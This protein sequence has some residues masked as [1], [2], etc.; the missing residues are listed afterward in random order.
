MA[1]T[2]PIMASVTKPATKEKTPKDADATPRVNIQDFCE[3]HYEDIMPVIMDKIR[4]DK[5]KKVHA[6]LDR[7]VNEKENSEKALKTQVSGPSPQ[8]HRRQSAFDRLSD[9]YSPS[10]TK[11]GSDRETRDRSHS[12]SRPHR[13][14][15]EIPRCIHVSESVVH[16]DGGQWKTIFL[17][18]TSLGWDELGGALDTVK[19]AARV[20]F[21]E[22][23][24]ESIDGYKDLKAAFL[25]YFMQQKKYV[26][27]PVEIHNIKQR[28]G[29]TIEEFMERFKVETGRMKGAPECMRISGFMHG[30]NN[31]ELTKRLNEHVPKTM[32]EMMI[33]TT[34]FIQ[35]EAAAA[36]KKKGHTS[37]RTQDQSK[38][39][40]SERRSD[41]RGQPREGRGSSKFTPLTRTPKEILA[42]EA[43]KFKP[44]PPMVTPV[45]KRSSNKFCDF[46]NDKGHS[47]DECMQLKKQ[48]EELVR[49]GKLSHLIKEIKQG[50]DQPKVG[51][52]EV[53]AKDKSMAI[54]MIQPWHRMT[55]QKVTQSFERVSKITFPS[56]TTSSGTE[57]PFVIEAEISGHMIHRMYVDGG[58]QQKCST[59]TA[60]TGNQEPN[61][62]GDAIHST[63]SWMNFMIVRS[64]SP[65][66]GIIGRPGIREI[67]AVPSTAHIMLKFPVDGGIVTIHSTILIPAECTTVITSSKEIPKEAGVRHENFKVA[68]H[69]NFPDQEPS[70][71]TRVPRSIAEHRLNIRE[72]CSPVRQK[73][74]GQAPE[75]AK[76]IQTKVQ[77]LVEAGIMR[78]VYYH[79]WLSNP[80][81]V[82]KHD[83]S[84]RMCVD[85]TDLNKA[86]PQDCYPLPEIDWKVESL[87]GYPF[88]CFLN[89]Y[90]G[91][92]QIQMA[93]SDEEKMAFHTSHE[94]YCYTKMPFGLKNV[95]ATH[96]RLVDKAFD[97]QVG[98]NIEVYVDDLVIKSHTEAEML[99][100]IDETFRTLRKINMKLNPKKCTFGA[101]ERM[102]LGYMIS[103]EGIKPCPDKTKVVLQLPSPRTIKEVQSLNGKLASLNRF[104]SKSAKKS[105]PLFKTLNKCI[106][107]SEF[108]WTPDAEQAFNLSELPL[109]I[110]ADFLVEKPDESM[111]DTSMVETPQDPWTLFTDGSSCVDGSGA[112]LILTS[113]KGTEWEYAMCTFAHLSKQV[114]VEILK[115][116]SIQEKEVTTVVEEDGLTWMTPIIEYLKEG[117][118]PEDKKEA[119]KLRIKARQYELW[120]GVRYRRSFLKP[121]LRCVGP[122]KADYVIREIHEGSCSMHAEP[123][124]VVANAMRLG[125]YWPTMHRDARNVIRASVIHAEIRMPTYRTTAVDAV[126]NDE[127]LRLNLDFLEERHEQASIRE[128]KAK[129]QMTKYY[130]A[131]V[132]GVTFR[133]RDFVYR[134]NDASHAVAGGKLG[135]KWEGP[136][137][138]TKALEDG[139][140]R[141]RSM[142]GIVLP[143]T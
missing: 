42:T 97:S 93:E 119:S 95:G 54:Y 64:L 8:G 135:S 117:T 7:E 9:T 99:R 118:I 33:T 46:H 47:T 140:Y 127:E 25:A 41:F 84:W 17:K 143:R 14:R 65:Y 36:G 126:H 49:A 133:P 12:R 57:G 122:L 1:N 66:N 39:H 35:G 110:L 96:Q 6:R 74:R 78:E 104:I 28:D 116:K 81:M 107:K 136:Y 85:F 98:R 44:P 80:V 20:W 34:A 61:G 67:Q 23:P 18:G 73:K 89:A 3:E 22:L 131:R 21:D 10:T 105:L 139:A 29:E 53:P 38:R 142:D 134:S 102:F 82:K 40:A 124:S 91:Y 55:R 69:L 125:Y 52:K 111:P 45:E 90:K 113:P 130:N 19:R 51:K 128:A 68:L 15:K 108:H 24:P 30:V 94:V 5:R 87:C 123:R 77:K 31:P 13:G 141:L 59:N 92:H 114:L 72:G 2:T 138:A 32:E 120:E 101:V 58:S 132:R 43:G 60:S 63:K 88:K 4:R 70:D 76:A 121:W 27:D 79:E 62:S 83:G 26:K 109:L 112:G 16:S 37:W 56:L 75:R 86:Y 106:K 48:I 11:S 115:E 137:E 50:R 71:M 100:D 103:P 129:L